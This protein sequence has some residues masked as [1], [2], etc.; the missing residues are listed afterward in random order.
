VRV[1]IAEDLALLRDGLV[2]LLRDND[3]E[4]VAEVGDADSL[5]HAVLRERLSLAV[6]RGEPRLDADRRLVLHDAEL[7]DR[8]VAR[9]EDVREEVE[10]ARARDVR[11]GPDLRRRVHLVAV[12]IGEARLPA[13]ERRLVRLRDERQPP[14]GAV[15]LRERQVRERDC[16][17]QGGENGDPAFHKHRGSTPDDFGRVGRGGFC[18][19]VGEESAPGTNAVSIVVDNVFYG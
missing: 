17:R 3:V 13:I 6:A 15:G 2:R 9:R 14:R 8:L 5:V 19:R 4:V 10:I 7:Q 12:G 16:G 1:V 11:V 18:A